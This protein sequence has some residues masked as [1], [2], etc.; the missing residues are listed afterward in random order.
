M[1]N[2]SPRVPVSVTEA[3]EQ[4]AEYFGFTASSYIQVAGGKV[5]EIPNPGLM[6]DDQQ[7]RW[8]ELQFDL[9]QCDREP[10]L[11]VPAQTLPD[12][13]T[14]AARTL[15]GDLISPY[16]KNGELLKPPYNVRLAKALFGDEGY[17]EYK[18]GGGIAN[19]IAME[20]ARMNREFEE[21]VSGGDPKSGGSDSPLAVVPSG[22]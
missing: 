10:D 22:D 1:G 8:E 18:A 2:N 15:K 4:A 14:L 3:K 17:A 9:E 20:W 19:Q 5:F 11:E 21:R 12:G 13:T 16:R 7:E 6:D